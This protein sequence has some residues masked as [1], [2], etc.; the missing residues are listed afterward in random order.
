VHETVSTVQQT[1]T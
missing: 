1:T